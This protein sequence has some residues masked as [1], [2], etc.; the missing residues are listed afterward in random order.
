MPVYNKSQHSTVEPDLLKQLKVNTI[1]DIGAN[2]GQ[3]ARYMYEIGYTGRIIS[4]EPISSAHKG[5]S[6]TKEKSLSIGRNDD[7]CLFFK[8]E[9]WIIAPRCG[10]G[11]IKD[12]REINIS[13]NSVASSF[14]PL[15]EQCLKSDNSTQ[16][17]N[18]ESCPIVTL[19]DEFEQYNKKGMIPFL[20]LDVQGYEHKV[21][22]GANKVL[23]KFLG[24]QFEASLLPLYDGETLWQG[25]IDLLESHNFYVH[26][27]IPA[28]RDPQ[29]GRLL[30]VDIIM[31]NKDIE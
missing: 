20:K 27:I 5:L 31:L 21:L 15:K 29:S 4:F 19:N 22:S 18:T 10:F 3:F 28:W 6:L 17:I 24:I 30:Q 1:F 13:K 2:E 12:V 16:Y 14:L 9:D 8:E 23:N 7:R 26:D 25:I 11:E